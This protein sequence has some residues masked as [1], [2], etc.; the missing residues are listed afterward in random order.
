M[1]TASSGH[2]V[3]SQPWIVQYPPGCVASHEREPFG[4]QSAA[5]VHSSPISR[6]HPAPAVAATTSSS[7]HGCDW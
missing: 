3:S 7:A 6:L 5:V 1:Q 2:D 4:L